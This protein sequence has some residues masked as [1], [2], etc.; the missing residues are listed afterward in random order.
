MV[1]YIMVSHSEF[2]WI[3]F[4]CVFV[5]YISLYFLFVFRILWGSFLPLFSQDGENNGLELHGNECRQDGSREGGILMRIY[6]MKLLF[7][8]KSYIWLKCV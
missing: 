6:S 2:L 1:L 8:I 7:L 3:C 5:G 4:C